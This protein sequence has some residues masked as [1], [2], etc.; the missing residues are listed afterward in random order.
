MDPERPRCGRRQPRTLRL[1]AWCLPPVSGGL[2]VVESERRRLVAVGVDLLL[3][4]G[5]LLLGEAGP[6]GELLKRT[7]DHLYRRTHLT[8]IH[9]LISDLTFPQPWPVYSSNCLEEVISETGLPACGVVGNSD[10]VT[11]MYAL[12][13]LLPRYSFCAPLPLAE[14][15]QRL[16]NVLGC[17]TTIFFLVDPGHTIQMEDEEPEQLATRITTTQCV[18]QQ[19]L[20]PR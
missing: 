11:T 5:D 12:P 2:Q 17:V 6:V 9:P 7:H 14:R 20:R 13:A 18:S 3:K 19:F 1:R 8:L 15:D 4:I 10:P 16:A